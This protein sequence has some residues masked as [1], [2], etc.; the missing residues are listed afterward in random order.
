MAAGKFANSRMNGEDADLAMRLGISPG[1]VHIEEP[2][3]FGYREHDA[4][5]RRDLSRTLAGLNYQLAAEKNGSYPGG[6]A[7]RME[8]I[9]IL[10][11][12][13]RPVALALLKAGDRRAAW[14]LYRQTLGWNL[15]LGRLRYLLGFPASAVIARKARLSP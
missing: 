5:V 11:G 2:I 8:R 4:N 14:A 3:T 7:R 10:G 6:A 13:A 15:R 12:Y 1:F 9:R